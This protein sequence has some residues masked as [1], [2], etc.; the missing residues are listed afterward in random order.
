MMSY[1][2]EWD[3]IYGDEWNH[4][5]LNE[6]LWQRMNDSVQI[7]IYWYTTSYKYDDVM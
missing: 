6:T 4:L 5:K 7:I 3:F 2:N 1:E